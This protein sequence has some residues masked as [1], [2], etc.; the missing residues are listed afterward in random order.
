MYSRRFKK[1]NLA[2]DGGLV[3]TRD[4]RGTDAA[5]QAYA[6][7][8]LSTRV[9]AVSGKM[10]PALQTKQG[11]A[12]HA[13]PRNVF[14]IEISTLGTVGKT[15]K[16]G[17]HSPSIKSALA[18]VASPGT[19][20]DCR[21]RVIQHAVAMRLKA[22]SAAALRTNHRVKSLRVSSAEY[23]KP[24]RGASLSDS[25]VVGFGLARRSG[26]SQSM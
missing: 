23:L 4:Y 12:I 18:G 16:S 14:E 9:A 19:K 2:R 3:G 24:C 25:A 22:I 13:F 1:G 17:R 21:K 6:E 15:L 8:S 11:S 20:A 26:A 5:E 7:E 10:Q